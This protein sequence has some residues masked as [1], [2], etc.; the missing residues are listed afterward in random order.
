MTLIETLAYN[1]H[2]IG[3]LHIAGINL[4]LIERSHQ[5][6]QLTGNQLVAA[7]GE[8]KSH[9]RLI[10]L[11]MR[12]VSQRMLHF[13]YRLFRHSFLIKSLVLVC[14]KISRS[15][16]SRNNQYVDK[17]SYIFLHPHL[18][19]LKLQHTACQH[20]N[21][22]TKRNEQ[23]YA[24]LAEENV[25]RK[26]ILK[27]LRSLVTIGFAHKQ[28]HGGVYRSTKLNKAERVYHIERI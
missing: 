9:R 4:S 22:M 20:H 2:Y 26:I 1:Q 15:N 18:W 10:H 28:K 14:S 17:Q 13:T 6:I 5:I 27:K 25:R 12:S 23:Y 8:G 3:A 24:H 19:H 21:K 11:S 16:K 7:N